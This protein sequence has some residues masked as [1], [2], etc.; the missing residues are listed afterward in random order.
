M[1]NKKLKG[2]IKYFIAVPVLL[3]LVLGALS[4]WRFG[5][6]TKTGLIFA[7]ILALYVIIV[8]VSYFR[9]MPALERLLVDYSMEQSKVQR[10]LMKNLELPYAILDTQGR[11]MWA[12]ELFH[13]VTQGASRKSHLNEIQ[14]KA[15]Q[16][17]K[18]GVPE[19][20]IIQKIINN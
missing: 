7:C 5:L 13:E 15:E 20:E 18:T 10:E 9:L 1:N 3:A 14:Q 6:E 19:T 16:M 2:K 17:L 11:V 12:N 8:I 4:V